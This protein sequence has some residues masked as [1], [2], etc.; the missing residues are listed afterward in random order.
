MEVIMDFRIKLLLAVAGVACAANGAEAWPQLQSSVAPGQQVMVSQRAAEQLALDRSPQGS[1]KSERLEQRASGPTWVI[2]V[3][4]Y[5]EPQYVTR[6][7][8]DA[9]SGNVSSGTPTLG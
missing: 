7:E 4:R 6:V 3:G 5:N 9:N 2:D 8:I 1:I